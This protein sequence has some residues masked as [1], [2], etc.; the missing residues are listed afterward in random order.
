MKDDYGR[1]IESKQRRNV[2]HGKDIDAT[3]EHSALFPF[4]RDIVRWAVRKGRAALFLDTGLGKT[5]CQTE[6]ARLIGERTLI[7]APLSVARQTV[8]L[9]KQVTGVGVHYTRS[10]DDL[11]DGIN[12]TNYEMLEKFDAS[13]FGAVVLDE[14]SILKALDGVT[15][16]LLTEMFSKIPYRLCCTATPAPN[17]EVE[18]GNHAEFLGVMK[19]NEMLASFF[20]H[21]NKA[22]EVSF[23]DE[24]GNMQ[25]LRSKQAGANGQEWRLRNYARQSFYKWLA[26]W[27]MAVRKPSDLG[28]EDG[29]FNLPPLNILPQWVDVDV[30]PDGQLLFTGLKGIQGRSAVRK[31]TMTD[32]VRM[33]AELI[34]ASSEPWVV[35]CGRND[36]SMELTKAISGAEEL[37]GQ[38]SPEH[39]AET[40][41]RFQDGAFRV[42]V[43]KGKIA[44]FGTNLQ[45]AHNMAFVGLSD[46]WEIYY[47]CIR[48]EWRFGQKFPVNVHIILSTVERE[49]YDNILRKEGIAK[50]LMGE[51]IAHV[52]TYE[53]E[54]LGT[55]ET[56]APPITTVERT[57]HGEN[58]TAM[59][60]DSCQRLAEV[61]DNSIDV[62]VYSPPFADLFTYSA[63]DLDLGNSKDWDEFFQHYK[64]IISHIL[65][66]TKPGRISC[67]H[68][69][70]IA[71]MAMKDGYIGMRDFPGAVIA[72]HIAEGWV[73]Y[74]YAVVSKNPQAQAIRTKAKALLF[75]QLRRDSSE[76]RPAILDRVIFFRKPG[77]SEIAVTPVANGELNN[78]TWIDWAGAIWTG[79]SESD[80]LQYTTARAADDE[81][82]I[83]PLQL[84][85]IER[86]IK[87]YS[88]PGETLL[89]PFMGIGSEAYCAI[90][91][92]RKAV[93]CELK[94]SYYNIAIQ[95]LEHV[96]AE[97][98]QSTIFDVVEG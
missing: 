79:I 53:R 66:A 43:T 77:K 86:C 63:S 64:Y 90:K 1:F 6:W 23:E 45:N 10:G 87:L 91:Y 34:N 29:D 82:H 75:A 20:I 21:A 98:H 2:F 65:R 89:T 95:N 25:V 56:V 52:K 67:V 8:R 55:M 96:E 46:S 54:E 30:V 9:A 33:A 15:R 85:T 50:R 36:E 76:S 14:S 27:A 5:H 41:E 48:R 69:A 57:E 32:R 47:Q 18:I 73:Y 83:C 11:I 44:G 40:I 13:K 60:G 19:N 39:K 72:A 61:D 62:S 12:I 94:E 93:G 17:D 92:G 80:T 22:E 24:S 37:V 88:N 71:A 28:Y 42:L 70:D 58:W 4:Q 97:T 26:T 81:K 31:A 49:I 74:G 68:T 7:V 35:W 16:R 84:G 51:L 59:L 3:Q 38:D 78:E